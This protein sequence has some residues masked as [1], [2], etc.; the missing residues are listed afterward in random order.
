M[1]K[2]R[3]G[4]QLLARAAPREQVEEDGQVV[5]AGD[6]LLDAHQ[7]HVHL[8]RGGREPRVAFILHDADRARVGDGEVDARHAHVGGDEVLAEVPAG[9]V[10]KLAVLG[11]V[12]LA[13]LVL[14]E[15]AHVGGRHV[16]RGGD[17]VDRALC[18]QLDEVF[19]QVG[20]HR[21]H[22]SGGQHVIDLQLLADHRLGLDYGLHAVCSRAMSS[23][24]RLAS[25]A[26]CA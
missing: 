22:P 24:C 1:E 2:V 5:D 4:G 12:R 19:A 15:L 10:G 21:A 23:T 14:E 11:G 8:G 25:S 16:Q 6:D 26:F 17:D 18:G 20:F 7:G 3:I 9:D 13:E